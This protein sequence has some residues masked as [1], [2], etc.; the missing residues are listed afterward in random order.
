MDM[1]SVF[2]VQ[3]Y[4]SWK[5][6]STT[7]H[8][9]CIVENNAQRVATPG[10]EPTNPVTEIDP[11]ES[12]RAPDRPVMNCKSN[13]VALAK[14]NYLGPRLHPRALLGQ[15]KFAA[16]KVSRWFRQQNRYLNRED[17]LSVQILV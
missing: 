11:I 8:L 17:V 15:N 13:R 10:P 4:L 12:P 9:L 5:K 14:G 7:L 6:T 2:R 16:C 1:T 3:S